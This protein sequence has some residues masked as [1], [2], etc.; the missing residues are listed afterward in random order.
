MTIS[1]ARNFRA[2]WNVS[3]NAEKHAVVEVGLSLSGDF[4]QEI[5]GAYMI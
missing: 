5:H 4:C 1:N 2:N 3:I